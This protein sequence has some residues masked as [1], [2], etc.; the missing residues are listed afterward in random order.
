MSNLIEEQKRLQEDAVELLKK[1]LEKVEESIQEHKVDIKSI[2]G[3]RSKAILIPIVKSISKDLYKLKEENF[4]EVI[5]KLIKMEQNYFNELFNFKNK[6]I[7]NYI[8]TP[9]AKALIDRRDKKEIDKAFKM[10]KESSRNFDSL[11]IG[12]FINILKKVDEIYIELF[13]KLFKDKLKEK[14]QYTSALLYFISSKEA[15]YALI[16]SMLQI[17]AYES[18]KNIDFKPLSRQNRGDEIFSDIIFLIQ[19]KK[20]YRKINFGNVIDDKK[21][22]LIAQALIDL[23]IE[24]GYIEERSREGFK[25]DEI[26]NTIYIRTTDKFEEKIKNVKEKLINATISYPPMVIPPIDWSDIDDGGFL[27]YEGSGKNFNLILIKHNLYNRFEKRKVREQKGKIPQEMLEGINTLQKT[28]FKINKKVL[29]VILKLNKKL[30]RDKV[31]SR[32]EQDYY[33]KMNLYK[34]IVDSRGIKTETELVEFIE[35]LTKREAIKGNKKTKTLNKRDKKIYSKVIANLDNKSFWSRFNIDY[36]LAKLHNSLDILL[37]IAKKFKDYERIYFVWQIDFRGRVYPVQTLLNPQ[38]GDVAKSLLLFDKEEKLNDRGLFWFKVHGANLYGEVDK[39]VFEKRI[40]WIDNHKEDIVNSAKD[41][42]NCDFWKEADEPFEFLAFCFEYERYIKEPNNFKTSLPV[43]VDGSNNGLQHISTLLRDIE[44]AKKVN[45]L[46]TD[47]VADIYRFIADTLKE[48]LERDRAKFEKRKERYI[49]EGDLYFKKVKKLVKDKR[50]YAKELIEKVSSLTQ[51]RAENLKFSTILNL[52]DDKKSYLAE[53]EDRLKSRY[54]NVDLD[55][56]KLKSLVIRELQNDAD[57]FEL[58]KEI[59]ILNS[60]GKREDS[61]KEFIEESLIS[62]LLKNIEIDRKFVK[63]PVMTDSYGS[64]KAGKA[65][66]ILESIEPLKYK[67]N[68]AGEDE[69]IYLNKFS[70]YI[71]K[72]IEEAIQKN[73]QASVKYEKFIKE[74]GKSILSSNNHISWLTPLGFKVQQ[75]EFKTR[76]EFI[77]LNDKGRITINIFIDKID[78]REHRKGILPNFIH[79]LDA[80]HLYQSVNRAKREGV[81][82]FMTVHD[83]FATLPNSMDRLSKILRE[84]FINLYKKPILEELLK[85]TQEEFKVKVPKRVPYIDRDSFNLEDIKLS[86]YFFA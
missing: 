42:I 7:E 40:E 46:P 33:K 2:W 76:K 72:L 39:E 30:K 18:E 65:K 19:K 24:L 38:G 70:N 6:N 49:K 1:K 79:S 48:Y 62:P 83:S 31:S 23:L 59:G 60:K 54:S 29:D 36:K 34:E 10:L 21:E 13:P 44:S 26:D 32:V 85:N 47:K 3:E 69:D 75:L 58:E 63:K 73:S 50:I 57:S 17:Q 14:P 20:Q 4:K 56:N 27:K 35:R 74:V 82:Y 64:S 77:N 12:E 22:Q 68:F 11:T 43:A 45:V 5:K 28:P 66:D 86:K 37:N 84:E 71:A 61:D 55:F 8:S 25:D 41:P 67:I 53:V 80:T 15:A 51:N 81:D 52:T 16:Y 78:K 9:L